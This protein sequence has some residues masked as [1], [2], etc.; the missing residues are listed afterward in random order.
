[1]QP[2]PKKGTPERQRLIDEHKACVESMKGV[3]GFSVLKCETPGDTTTVGGGFYDDPLLR[4]VL[5]R[6]RGESPKGKLI[7]I[8]TK[9]DKEWRIARLSGIRGV[10]PKFIDDTVYADEQEIQ[11]TIFLMRLEELSESYGMPD[12]FNEG[13]KR[14]DDNWPVT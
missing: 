12:D 14:R 3:A 10:P 13:W 8:C 7:V 9:V 5:L 2:I 4:R 1:M 11:H 6:M